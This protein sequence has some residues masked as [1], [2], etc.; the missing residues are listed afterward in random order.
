MKFRN[1]GFFI[2]MLSSLNV[3]AADFIPV[4]EQNN[5][6]VMTEVAEQPY[7]QEEV[8]D[9]LSA[10]EQ[11]EQYLE[12]KDGWSEGYDSEKKRI[13]V[14]SSVS[15]VTPD[16]TTDDS[17]LQKRSRFALRASVEAKA[18]VVRYMNEEMEAVD[19]FTTPGTD[20]HAKLNA[21]YIELENK[22][23]QKREEMLK[24]LAQKDIAEADKLAGVTWEDQVEEFFNA[25]IKQ[26]D[27][28]YDP[29]EIKNEK[30]EKYSLIKTEYLK[31]LNEYNTLEQEAQ[32]IRGNISEESYTGISAYAKAPIMG[33]SIVAQS[34]SY[35]DG[36]YEV[37][38][39]TVWSKK[40]ENAAASILT[41]INYKPK[42]KHGLSVT[43]WLKSQELSTLVGPRQ[44]V[45]KNGE[46]WFM[47]AYAMPM[48]VKGSKKNKNKKFAD[49]NARK[50]TAM[51]LY[52]DIETFEAS[53]EIMQ[54]IEDPNGNEMTN[55][56]ESIESSLTAKLS[57]RN[58][59][60]SSK[61]LSK[62]V[63]HPISGQKIY[64]VV[65][66]ISGKSASSALEMQKETYRSAVKVNKNLQKSMAVQKQ[67]DKSL[68]ESKKPV[69]LTNSE[70]LDIKNDM[71]SKP[72]QSNNSTTQIKKSTGSSKVSLL[73]APTID[74]DD[75]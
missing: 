33:T 54:T 5:L 55:S 26:L 2:G 43:Q 20:V 68:N 22:F 24:L 37:A 61:L 29:N 59:K 62:T 74:E 21:K 1:I 65:Y 25:V 18:Q 46:R 47:G 72:D 57:K 36:E 49:L 8:E 3:Y 50:E 69:T 40:L 48:N 17:F 42:P 66:G 75:F 15:F 63:K 19:Q 4:E 64:V 9:E 70:S 53:E 51:A 73:N 60:G 12:S 14:I 58:V 45:D 56:A 52:S 7:E 44:F 13:F 71:E 23:I 31:V 27:E 16:P 6:E 39:L 10:S 34:E 67:Q 30:E 38:V 41:G 28:S 11:L 32:T 35:I